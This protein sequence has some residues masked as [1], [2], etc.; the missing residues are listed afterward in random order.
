MVSNNQRIKWVDLVRASAI[1]FVVLCHS[2]ELVYSFNLE[3]VL[4]LTSRSKWFSFIFFTIGRLGVPLFLMVSGS[5]LLNKDYD[6]ERIKRFWKKN[7]LHLVICTMV[8]IV[9]YEL[10]NIFYLGVTIPIPQIIAD[11]LFVHGVSF[12][13]VWYMPMILGMYILLPFV[14]VALKRV[15]LKL[16]VFPL[17][18][19]T[20]YCFGVSLFSRIYNVYSQEL[21]INTQLSAGFSGGTYGLYIIYGY[22]VQKGAFKRIKTVIVS[23]FTLISFF[24]SVYIQIWFYSKGE[25]YNI[26]YDNLFLLAA[27]VGIF[28]LA[29]RLKNVK[30]Y[31]TVKFISVYSFPLYLL[32]MIVI[33]VVLKHIIDINVLR[34]AQ[35]LLLW[36]VACGCGLIIAI[37]IRLIPKVG[38]YVLYMK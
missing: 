37:I 11:M 24:L 6:D 3:G 33:K 25:V 38:K 1:L 5:L 31:K 20:I 7:W 18:V 10:F 2:V 13:H 29:S 30:C 35:A 14:S 4:S 28:E 9:I 36:A 32:H 8:W 12:A 34:P 21:K 26:W 19:F 16:L 22:L 23:I 15:N 27:A 17:V